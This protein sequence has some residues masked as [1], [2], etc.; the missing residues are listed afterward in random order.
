YKNFGLNFA[1]R[2]LHSPLGSFNY[3]KTQPTIP[4][5][6]ICWDFLHHLAV[7]V[8]GDVS[9]CVRFDPKK[10]GVVGNVTTQT[11]D[12]IWN[13]PR[14]REYLQLHK[15]GNRNQVPLCELCHFWGVPTGPNK[16]YEE[17]ESYLENT[18]F[19]KINLTTDL[20]TIN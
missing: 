8:G 12:E 3:K 13:S 15:T 6:G 17:I 20:D 2:V 16:P 11:L 18:N 14:R 1:R 9:I 4:E 5:I 7:N 10:L 19:K